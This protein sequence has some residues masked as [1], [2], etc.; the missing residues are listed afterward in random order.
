MDEY[1]LVT[2]GAGYI[3]SHVNKLLNL[4]GYKTIV[5]DNLVNG[6]EGFVKWGKFI[7]GDI[8]DEALLGLIFK[9]YRV[10]AI[11]HFSAFADVGES[12]SEPI[13]YYINNVNNT[14]ILL[15]KAI[16]S[17]V[18]YFIFSSTCAVYGNPLRI[19]I[20]EKHPTDPIN[21]YGR[22]K[23][24]VEYALKDFE[25]AYGLKYVSLRYFNAAG[26]DPEGELGE[27]HER[28]T[29]LIP[30]TLKVALGK[31]EHLEIFGDDYNT[32][33]GTCI[34]D[35]IHVSDLAKAHILALEY[36]FN[37]GNSDVFNLGIG[38]GFSVKEVIRA[39]EEVTGRKVRFVIGDRRPGDPPVL[40][41]D[42]SKAR[43]VLGWAPEFTDIKDIIK[44]A[45]LWELR[46]GI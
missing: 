30:I 42:A 38:R 22:S 8:G 20:D 29:R 15:K 39:V 19:P 21:P 32:P 13:K 27:W 24:I 35:Y 46:K 34:R 14:L 12:V 45:Y 3:G 1:V 7:L 17:N 16:E 28:E 23:L 43:K 26:A 33:D 40:I 37:G 6:R 41:A 25:L 44:T 18:K 36:L 9:N 31:V 5:V 2:G 10:K 11:M 4:K